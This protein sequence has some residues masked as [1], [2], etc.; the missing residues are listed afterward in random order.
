MILYIY[1]YMY[2]KWNVFCISRFPWFSHNSSTLVH[3]SMKVHQY[4]LHRAVLLG[5]RVF[6]RWNMVKDKPW[7]LYPVVNG[8]S[9]QRSVLGIH[10]AYIFPM[11]NGEPVGATWSFPTIYE[12]KKLHPGWLEEN[13]INKNLIEFR[14][15]NFRMLKCMC[16]TM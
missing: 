9:A 8:G 12:M 6:W 5:Q 16:C 10:I 7:L 3:G 14:N 11:N 2:Y 4:R 15:G 1:I 13:W